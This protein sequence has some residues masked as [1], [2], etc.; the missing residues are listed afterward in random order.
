MWKGRV[1]LVVDGHQSEAVEMEMG[2]P[3]GLPTLHILFAIYV[4]EVFKQV[5]QEVEGSMA[6]SFTDNCGWLVTAD[7]VGQLCEQLE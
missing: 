7:S 3:Q 6:T 4:S 2:V 5:E 1:S